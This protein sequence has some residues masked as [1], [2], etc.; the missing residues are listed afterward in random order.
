MVRCPDGHD[1]CVDSEASNCTR[2]NEEH[3]CW[4][5]HGYPP[6]CNVTVDKNDP[7]TCHAGAGSIQTPGWHGFLRDGILV[8]A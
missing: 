2:K 1:W 3:H 5:R 8:E 6:E 7:N 4:V